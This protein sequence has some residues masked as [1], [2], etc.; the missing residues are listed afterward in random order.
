MHEVVNL[1]IENMSKRRK[2]ST[3]FSRLCANSA[4]IVISAW[5]S[6]VCWLRFDLYQQIVCS[7]SLNTFTKCGTRSKINTERCCINPY[8][9]AHICSSRLLNRSELNCSALIFLIFI[10]AKNAKISSINSTETGV[11]IKKK[12][13]KTK[14]FFWFIHDLCMKYRYFYLHVVG[15]YGVAFK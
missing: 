8:T 10:S 13:R 11:Y 14:A 15:Q 5:S 9:N 3:Y 7:R 12:K 4:S 1:S 2:K 6:C